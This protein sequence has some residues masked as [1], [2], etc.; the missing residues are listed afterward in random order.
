[1]RRIV[2]TFR[3]GAFFFAASALVDIPSA[4]LTLSAANLSRR[5][6]S[7]RNPLLTGT[8]ALLVAVQLL[9]F[10]PL[11]YLILLR[12]ISARQFRYNML[13]SVEMKKVKE[14]IEMGDKKRNAKGVLLHLI[15]TYN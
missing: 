7:P 2:Q 15:H 10:R 4:R 13:N 14:K 12:L 8:A 1:M 11:R 6:R 3:Y 9:Q 5:L